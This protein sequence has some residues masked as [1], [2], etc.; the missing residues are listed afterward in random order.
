MIGA[1][2]VVRDRPTVGTDTNR[3]QSNFGGNID[4]PEIRKGNKVMF[5]VAHEGGLLYLGDLHA[6]QASEFGG[7]GLETRGDVTLRCDVIPA[8]EIPFVRIETPD[9]IIQLNSY[10]P[11]DEGL[12]QANLWMLDWL[13]DDYG[14][15]SR[16]A[17]MTLAANGDV[18]N[19]VYA[20]SM[21]GPNNYTIGVSF[22]KRLLPSNRD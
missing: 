22:P 14:F 8:K 3:T 18:R 11:I 19:V 10:R 12:K 6:S 20:L 13:V 4:C 15:S 1:I 16:D 7:T 17:L 2:G 9:A 21:W 5:P